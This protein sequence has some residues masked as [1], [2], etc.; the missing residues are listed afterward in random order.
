MWTES[1]LC[2][3]CVLPSHYFLPEPLGDFLLL[4]LARPKVLTLTCWGKITWLWLNP[5]TERFDTGQ[6]TCRSFGLFLFLFLMS[7]PLAFPP[8]V[9]IVVPQGTPPLP[10]ASCCDKCSWSQRSHLLSRTIDLA[11]WVSSSLPQAMLS[12]APLRMSRFENSEQKEN[13]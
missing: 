4:S 3:L 11:S 12:R 7:S 10:P 9:F 2:S 6:G 5:T 8:S 13:L 1:Y